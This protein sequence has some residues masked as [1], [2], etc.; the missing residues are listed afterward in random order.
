VLNGT[1]ADTFDAGITAAG[2]SSTWN[3]DAAG[4]F[5]D[6]GTFNGSRNAAYLNLGSYINNAKGQANGLFDLTMDISPTTG[7]W[8]S[9][10]FSTLNTPAITFDMT[11]A[12]GIATIIYRPTNQPL[13]LDMFGGVGSANA[14]DGPTT[15]G[16]T[17]TVTVRLDLTPLGGYNGINNFGTAYFYDSVLGNLGSLGD[18]PSK[19]SFTYTT[20]QNFGS[21]L[22]SGGAST[23]GTFDNLLFT[24]VPEPCTAVLVG[25]GGFALIFR[26]RR[27]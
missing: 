9:L 25:L 19:L 13:E 8:I 20:P 11:G 4:K 14:I 2:G 5:F 15:S 26:R 18:T 27:S 21:I 24:Q 22:I 1:T 3:A 6:N 23:T 10:G 17:R 7:S 16:G 12:N